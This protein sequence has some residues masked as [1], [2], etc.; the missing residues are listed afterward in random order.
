MFVKIMEAAYS[1][2]TGLFVI[3]LQ[4]L[5]VPNVKLISVAQIVSVI[6]MEIATQRMVHTAVTVMVIIVEDIVRFLHHVL[7]K[8]AKTMAHVL[9]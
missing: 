3:A 4:D 6:G 2:K 8:N 1:F 7:Q 9:L 5:R